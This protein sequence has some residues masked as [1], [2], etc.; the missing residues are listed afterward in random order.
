VI[1]L[2]PLHEEAKSAVDTH[3]NAARCSNSS[4][5]KQPTSIA[6]PG[7]QSVTLGQECTRVAG[8]ALQRSTGAASAPRWPVMR[9]TQRRAVS[10]TSIHKHRSPK[11][12]KRYW[13]KMLKARVLSGLI[14]NFVRYLNC[15]RVPV[16]CQWTRPR[17]SCEALNHASSYTT[18]SARAEEQNVMKRSH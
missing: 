12:S 6:I 11:S 14:Q 4:R 17:S 18:R 3:H 8:S 16:A 15:Q 5:A 9:S 13:M 7:T 1:V 2:H 10:P